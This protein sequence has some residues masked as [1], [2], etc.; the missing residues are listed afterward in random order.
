MIVDSELQ[1]P[2][3]P[4]MKSWRYTEGEGIAIEDVFQN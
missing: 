4:Q 1:A 3:E 2:E